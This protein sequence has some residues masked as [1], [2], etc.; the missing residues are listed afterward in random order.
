MESRSARIDSIFMPISARRS[1][2]SLAVATF[3]CQLEMALGEEEQVLLGGKVN[4]ELIQ[5][6]WLRHEK[7]ASLEV[8]CMLASCWHVFK[9]LSLFC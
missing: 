3:D 5:M 4:I 1:G 8:C 6:D 7:N 9:V 2:G